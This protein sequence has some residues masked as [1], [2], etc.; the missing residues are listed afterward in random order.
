MRAEDPKVFVEI[1]RGEKFPRTKGLEPW[2]KVKNDVLGQLILSFM[3][4]KPGTARS[5]KKKIFG[6]KTTYE[7]I[8]H[9]NR[10]KALLVDLLQLSDLYDK[11][12]ND[13][14]LNDINEKTTAK[15]G[16][17]SVIAI[18]GFLIKWKRGIVDF[19]KTTSSWKQQVQEDN[20]RTPFL[21][22]DR[23]DDKVIYAL[24]NKIVIQLRKEIELRESKFT[25]I[26][27]FFKLDSTYNDIIL[28][29]FE[30]SFLRYEDDYEDIL[31][32]L[33]KAFID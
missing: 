19:N 24:F 8:F 26:S 17:L 9:K 20:I 23:E 29:H 2:Q 13:N 18:I 21:N 28:E 10:E 31:R 33:N 12:L 14:S 5:N 32:R 30:Q 22:Q 1:K 27:N 15:N 7:N 3:L 4:Q 11:W 16:K 25:S 6:E